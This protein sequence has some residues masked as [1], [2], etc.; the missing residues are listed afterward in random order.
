MK[1]CE[2]REPDSAVSRTCRVK[3]HTQH[4][5]TNHTISQTHTHHTI[6]YRHIHIIPYHTDTH[7]QIIS[8]HTH[9]S[10]SIIIPYHHTISSYHTHIIPYHTHIHTS[11]H[12][13]HTSYHIVHTQQASDQSEDVIFISTRLD[14][15][16]QCNSSQ[17]QTTFFCI[18]ADA[19]IIFQSIAAR[20]KKIG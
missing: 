15:F 20:M 5:H 6:S 11:H 13:I 7:K 4:T 18:W 1:G 17:I 16:Q 3:N 9:T 8:Y 2:F 19:C 10:Y 14:N 12:I